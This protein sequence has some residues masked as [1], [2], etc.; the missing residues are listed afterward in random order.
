M[1]KKKNNLGKEVNVEFEASITLKN[2]ENK[3]RVGSRFQSL[4]GIL[5]DTVEDKEPK[6]QPNPQVKAPLRE[7]ACTKDVERP[8]T[9]QNYGGTIKLKRA[10][11]KEQ[12]KKKLNNG[13]SRNS[14]SE[15]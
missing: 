11:I 14:K 12:K 6:A 13:V 8:Q 5:T 1:R 3:S 2:K 9:R 7:K 15:L 10:T 4:S